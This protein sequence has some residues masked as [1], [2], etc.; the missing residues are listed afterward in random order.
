M[1]KV[2]SIN[3]N[4]HAYQIDEDAYELLQRYLERAA[5]DLRDNPDRDEILSDLEQAIAE[6]GA[7][8]LGAHRSVLAHGDIE[9][10]LKEMG[11]VESG[12][13]SASA[14]NPAATATFGG[15]AA[16][17]AP[18]HL[19]RV[20]DGAWV[21]GVCSGLA[22][23]FSQDVTVFR[24]AF[25]LLGILDLS[26]F[27]A[28]TS[29]L[30]Y[31]ALCFLVPVAQTSEERAAASGLPFDAQ[32]IIEQ[33]K[34]YFSE[35]KAGKFDRA[36]WRS[37]RREWRRT[38]REWKRNM[39]AMRYGAPFAGYAGPAITA[40]RVSYGVISPALTMISVVAFWV[41]AF[42]VL[43]LIDSRTIYHWQLPDTVPTWL[44]VI[45]VWIA[46]NA[47]TGPIDGARHHH[48]G[49]F[50]FGNRDPLM[51]AWN[52]M[53]GVVFTALILWYGYTHVPEVRDLVQRLP[54]I[55][56]KVIDW[57]RSVIESLR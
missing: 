36:K 15:G 28:P 13:G 2:F 4:G 6:K 49:A 47:I 30:V 40:A 16:A 22:A 41:A 43:S 8:F 32:H 19:Y 55:I 53:F 44:A 56:H 12:A 27:H 25:V 14:A 10:I 17:S 42:A 45:G 39:R 34:R 35:M 24:G 52:G 54:D 33:S 21:A 38:R 18:R 48:P 37:D 3:L 26:L 31:I 23:Y 51:Q 50:T 57:F 5:L 9:Q 1:K 7:R 29:V 20:L 46:Y 11:P